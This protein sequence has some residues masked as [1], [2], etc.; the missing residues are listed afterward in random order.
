M[1]R[2]ERRSRVKFAGGNWAREQA[3]KRSAD[4]MDTAALQMSP[5][6]ARRALA[7]WA[8]RPGHSQAEVDALNAGHVETYIPPIGGADVD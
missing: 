1:S 5:A 3:A 2:K 7:E 8:A 6:E 4:A